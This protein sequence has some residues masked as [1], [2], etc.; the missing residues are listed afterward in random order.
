MSAART[1]CTFC[2]LING[3]GEVSVCYEDSDAMA[4]MDIQP[5][6]AGHVLVAPRQHYASLFDVPQELGDHLFKVTMRMASAVRRVTGCDD[7]NIVVSSGAAA[8]QDVFHY[9][10][11]I[12]P[13]RQDDG[14]DVQLPFGGSEMPD[15]TMLDAMAARI[16]AAMRDPMRMGGGGGGTGADRAAGDRTQLSAREGEGPR[17]EGRGPSARDREVPTLVAREDAPAPRP[18]RRQEGAHGELV[19]DDV[20]AVA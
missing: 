14:F 16:I 12:I 2:D 4:F 20:E 8:G 11:H 18:L 15:R 17:A 10:V 1:H 13:R 19:R 9:H 6:N 7:M 5:V 3:A